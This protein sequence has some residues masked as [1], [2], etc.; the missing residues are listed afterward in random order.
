MDK[1][2]AF[3]RLTK[4]SIVKNYYWKRK[5]RPAVNYWEYGFFK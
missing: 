5:F 4:E 3:N 1:G 2:L